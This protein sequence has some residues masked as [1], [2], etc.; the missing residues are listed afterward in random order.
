[1]NQV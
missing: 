1:M